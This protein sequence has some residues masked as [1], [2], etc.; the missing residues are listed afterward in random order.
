LAALAF[1]SAQLGSVGSTAVMT[2]GLAIL[3]C[4]SIAMLWM[5]SFAYLPLWQL[6]Q[7]GKATMKSVATIKNTGPITFPRFF[8]S[9]LGALFEKE[10]IVLFREMKSALWFFFLLMLWLV[11]IILE[12]F[13]RENLI[14]HGEQLTSIVGQI[15]ALQVGTAIYFISAFILRFV[16]PAFSGEQKT[17]WIIGVSPLKTQSIFWS[18]FF[19]YTALFLVLGVVFCGLNFMII[20]MPIAQAFSFIVFL[21]LMIVFLVSF[22]LGLGALF[23]NFETDDPEILS[24]SLPGLG[25]IL[26]S[27][28]YGGFGTYLFYNYLTS[29]FILPIMAFDAVSIVLV[30]TIVSLALDS[31]KKFQFVKDVA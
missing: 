5:L 25:F 4:M 9:P 2:V 8:K 13:I 6:F 1:L 19:F 20:Q 28:S 31:L 26:F 18:K 24:T 10:G 29:G 14:H 17:A 27:L 16:F 15:E 7:E 30:L 22:G 3:F 23:P 11:Q 12:F 21:F